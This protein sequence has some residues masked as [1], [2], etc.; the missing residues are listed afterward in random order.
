MNVLVETSSGMA[1][2][3]LMKSDG[4]DICCLS[5]AA[6]IPSKFQGSC[7]RQSRPPA[8][9]AGCTAAP[10]HRLSCPK[11]PPMG[12]QLQQPA[13][14]TEVLTRPA[15][16][17]RTRL[18]CAMAADTMHLR[19]GMMMVHSLQPRTLTHHCAP[20]LQADGIMLMPSRPWALAPKAPWFQ[21]AVPVSMN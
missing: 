2:A 10:Q 14:N 21:A 11:L 8:A 5:L 9:A 6:D 19:L 17:W 15:V 18:I 4:Q 7:L 3:I 20:S 13:Q 12:L 1:A 16:V